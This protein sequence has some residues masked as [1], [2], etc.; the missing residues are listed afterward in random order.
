[1]PEAAIE[2][3]GVL[4]GRFLQQ[5]RTLRVCL[6]ITRVI[7]VRKQRAA[8]LLGIDLLDDGPAETLNSSMLSV[9]VVVELDEDGQIPKILP[10]PPPLGEDNSPSQRLRCEHARSDRALSRTPSRAAA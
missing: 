4:H 1:M 6:S 5:A 3:Q 2:D 8:H 7:H 10:S 9:A